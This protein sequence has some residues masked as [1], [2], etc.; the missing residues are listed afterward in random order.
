[1]KE[2]KI[3]LVEDH[4]LLRD[5]WKEIFNTQPDFD[6][7]GESDNVAH[8]YINLEILKPEIV[9]LDINLK[10]ESGLELAKKLR[11]TMPY[12]KI[13]VVS[14]HSEAAF[15]KKMF[16]F[17]IC[18]YVSKDAAATNVYDAIRSVARGE[19]YMSDDLKKNFVE[20][21][22][23]NNKDVE[24]SFKELEVVSYLCKGQTNKEIGIAMEISTKSVEGHKTNIYKKLKVNSP[25]AVMRYAQENGL[26]F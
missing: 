14:M 17:G 25:T 18:G 9:L 26:V 5:V 16:S 11:N 1:M 10:G 2:I 4:K 22:L 20:R 15:V 24:L 19:I 8:A 23:K 7:I 12:I 6:V 21:A 13:I 3:Y